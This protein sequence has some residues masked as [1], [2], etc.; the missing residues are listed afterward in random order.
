MADQT[1]DLTEQELANFKRN[2]LETLSESEK[3]VMEN[4]VLWELL[5]ESHKKWETN[6]R[7]WFKLWKEMRALLHNHQDLFWKFAITFGL[8]TR[9]RL[10]IVSR[11]KTGR[12]FAL[13]LDDIANKMQ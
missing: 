11:G 2:F 10:T 9:N 6:Y 13:L 12:R 5:Q 7:R 4:E 3:H 8:F 1:L